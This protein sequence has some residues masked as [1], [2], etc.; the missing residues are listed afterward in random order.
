MPLEAQSAPASNL[1]HLHQLA[2]LQQYH[3]HQHLL[4]QM[5]A[6]APQQLP[7]Q[8]SQQLQQQLQW[9]HYLLA[10]QH[11][12]LMA[13]QAAQQQPQQPQEQQV[14]QQ[15][16]SPQN[17]TVAWASHPDATVPA[18]KVDAAAVVTPTSQTFEAAPIATGSSLRLDSNVSQSLKRPSGSA[19][20]VHVEPHSP[21]A[22]ATS[23][24]ATLTQHQQPLNAAQQQQQQQQQQQL[25][26]LQA[27]QLQMQ[28]WPPV[29]CSPATSVP[30]S[31]GT[32]LQQQM[33][34]PAQ[35]LPQVPQQQQEQQQQQQ[36]ALM[37]SQWL[38]QHARVRRLLDC[39]LACLL[40]C[41][42]AC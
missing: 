1:L 6:Q 16:A 23:S 22:V 2:A 42:L 29:V 39:W 20:E 15:L 38:Q 25:M 10:Q 30:M 24:A 14:L 33:V 40:A 34:A 11:A 5:A 12:Q 4:Q 8:Q 21:P 31:G 18:P 17:S 7:E 35:L 27:L 28:G 32:N 37:Q 19:T 3:Q 13:A 41:L 36:Q 26:L 9:Q